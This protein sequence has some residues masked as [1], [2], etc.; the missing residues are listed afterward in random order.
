M[1]ILAIGA[2]PDDIE[3]G[4]G[5]LLIK[6]NQKGTE[7]KY[8]ICSLGEAGSNGTPEGRKE[9]AVNA[10]KLAGAEVEFLNLGGDCHIEYKPT[11]SIALAR[12]I[13]LHQPNIVLT[14]QLKENQHPD[15]ATVAKLTRDAC[16]LARYGGLSEIKDLPIHRVDALY[17]FSSSAE[18]D[19]KPDILVDVSDNFE[20]WQK[21][22]SCHTSQMK[23]RDYLELVSTK[24]AALG[25]TI[26]VKYAVALWTNDSIRIGHLS[27]L[28]LSSRNY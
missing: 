12:L 8:A 9:E 11:N 10:A 15:H 27:D 7:I 5:G 25:K 3:F 18:S 22:M 13:R 14:T 17:Y 19:S 24:S 26:G 4:C 20:T 6:E 1:K 21:A 2:H 16:R 23:T 28:S